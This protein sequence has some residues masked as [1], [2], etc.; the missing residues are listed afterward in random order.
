ME[1]STLSTVADIPNFGVVV[2][3]VLMRGGEP[4]RAG[5]ATIAKMAKTVVDLR[6]E[7][8][9]R[10]LAVAHGLGYVRIPLV[11]H[12]AFTD[13][14]AAYWLQVAREPE[15]H[16]V[17]C[18]CRAGSG[19]TG[20]AVALYR[21]MV[22]DWGLARI[23]AEAIRYRVPRWAAPWAIGWLDPTQ[24]SFMRHWIEIHPRAAA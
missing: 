2:E 8:D 15:N 5:F 18:Y 4:G 13:A 9:D 22:D 20:M 3:G 11:D 21:Y 6:A 24:R 16:P 17:F 1:A 19:R 10:A 14:E 12:S 7:Q 23:R